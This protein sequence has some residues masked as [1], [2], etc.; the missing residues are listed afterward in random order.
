M[1]SIRDASSSLMI[2][3][4]L[5][6]E[7]RE[8]SLQIL[9]ISEIEAWNAHL[10]YFEVSVSRMNIF[11]SNVIT[12]DENVNVSSGLRKWRL[13]T[14]ISVFFETGGCRRLEAMHADS[15]WS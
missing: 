8:Y 2:R 1:F 3:F 12:Y 5:R 11:L 7:R 14:A 13:I 9:R 6:I 4:V 15:T 10:V